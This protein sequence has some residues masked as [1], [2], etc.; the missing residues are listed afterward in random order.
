MPLD[1]DDSNSEDHTLSVSRNR[2][3]ASTV[4]RNSPPSSRLTGVLEMLR[5][6]RETRD[7][8]ERHLDVSSVESPA[9]P[10][11]GTSTTSPIQSYRSISSSYN[12]TMQSS[13][14][15]A[16]R[17]E[18]FISYSAR[19]HPHYRLQLPPSEFPLQHQS[20]DTDP[21]SMSNSN[22]VRRELDGDDFP[23]RLA[24]LRSNAPS[25]HE[26]LDA[27]ATELT[28][29]FT[30]S[31]S[32][33]FS[34]RNHHRHSSMSASPRVLETSYP[35]SPPS[36]RTES[37]KTRRLED[38]LYFLDMQR[39]RSPNSDKL[40]K[41]SHFGCSY[42]AES[43]WLRPGGRYHGVQ[44]IAGE[45]PLLVSNLARQLRAAQSSAT[46]EWKVEVIIDQVD[47]S[48]MSIAGSMKAYD[49]ANCGDRQNVTT[50]WTGEVS[51][52]SRLYEAWLILSKVDRLF[53]TS[54]S[55]HQALAG[56]CQ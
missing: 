46:K 5:V 38:V 2:I 8:N 18:G 1:P 37:E 53:V 10:R 33:S 56:Q 24:Y 50:F 23:S 28:I 40:R 51:S 35:S 47:Y 42:V 19:E 54:F 55:S 6:A 4:S 12:A 20:E 16:R 17:R 36:R 39:H 21:P 32:D 22:L 11:R 43:S 29:P 14:P 15:I 34:T 31:R 45:V 30:H 27:A 3:S 9:V 26:S 13:S 44:T 49:M 48:N 25:I 52:L 7:G 41:N